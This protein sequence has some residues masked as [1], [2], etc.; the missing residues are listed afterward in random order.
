MPRHLRRAALPLLVASVMSAMMAGPA[1]AQE[2]S[3]TLDPLSLP[4]FDATPAAVIAATPEITASPP[5]LDEEGAT[6][7]V[8]LLLACA[9]A[10]P[11]AIRYAIF[12]DAY[13]ARLFIGEDHADQPAFERMIAAGSVT[14]TVAPSLDGVSDLESLGDGRVAVTIEATT[15]EGSIQ[16]RVILAWDADAEA[17]LIDEIVSLDPPPAT[18]SA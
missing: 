1:A 18:P 4:L 9:G 8:A 14:D 13:L 10:E 12:T 5:Q 16:D 6:D 15:A 3:C 11:Q 7:A 2:P 17:W